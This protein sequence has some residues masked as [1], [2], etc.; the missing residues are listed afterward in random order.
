MNHQLYNNA[1]LLPLEDRNRELEELWAEFEDIPMDPETDQ[2]ESAFL[3]FPAGTHREEIWHW[4]DQRHSKGVYYL[5]YA[6]NAEQKTK[7]I[8]TLV[9]LYN[10]CDDCGTESCAF[11]RDGGCYFPM[12]SCRPPKIDED[13]CHDYAVNG[14][15][16]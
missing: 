10:L 7:K 15:S 3:H 2:I 8:S 14:C 16:L 11:Y 9:Q 4:F 1:Q 6:C 13:G 12:V 5:L